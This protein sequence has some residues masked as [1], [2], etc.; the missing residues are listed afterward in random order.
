MKMLIFSSSFGTSK[1]QKSCEKIEIGT[2]LRDGTA[3]RLQ[4]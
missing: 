3:W 4:K 1:S 2:T